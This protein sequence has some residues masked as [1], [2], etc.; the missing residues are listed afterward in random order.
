MRGREKAKKGLGFSNLANWSGWR[1]GEEICGVGIL[2]GV[3]QLHLF[4]V[5][6]MTMISD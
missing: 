6:L 2:S 4:R 5:V 3:F 1:G